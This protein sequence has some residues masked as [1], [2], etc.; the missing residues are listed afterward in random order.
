MPFSMTTDDLPRL[1]VMLALAAVLGYIAVVIAGGRVPLG[2]FGAI[3][4]GLLGA[5]LAGDVLRPAIPFGLPQEPQ[6]EGVMLV[7]AG[8]GA[9]L[10]ALGWSLLTA[11]F[12]RRRR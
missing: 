10:F 3:G 1:F 6:Q 12:S 2:A 5:W 9:F 8:L 7:T 4:F 11:P